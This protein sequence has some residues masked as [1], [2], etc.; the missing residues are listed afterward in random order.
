MTAL[1]ANIFTSR[2]NFLEG[3]KLTQWTI[4][5][6]RRGGPMEEVPTTSMASTILEIRSSSRVWSKGT[7]KKSFVSAIDWFISRHQWLIPSQKWIVL[8]STILASIDHYGLE[9]PPIKNPN[10]YFGYCCIDKVVNL[11]CFPGLE[12]VAN[13]SLWPFGHNCTRWQVHRWP[14]PN[15]WCQQ[16]PH[17]RWPDSTHE[18]SHK[19]WCRRLL[20][21][22]SE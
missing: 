7:L 12:N 21:H 15:Q 9:S 2:K 3:Q 6:A 4:I 13:L 18:L 1:F 20:V 14:F 19:D 10:S 17:Q 16:A 5:P 22:L 8:T 11:S